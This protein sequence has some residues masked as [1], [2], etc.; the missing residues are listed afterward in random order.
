MSPLLK[1]VIESN[2]NNELCSKIRSYLTNPKR[3]E[4]PQIYLKGLKVEN[5]LLMKRNWLWVANKNQLQL[6]VIKEIHNQPA[7]GH[8]STEKTLEMAWYHYYWPRVKEM[9]QQFIRNCYM[10]KQAK[11]AWDTYHSLLQLLL[12]PKQTWTDITIDFVVEL[13][14]CKA[15][16]QIYDA[17]LMVI[18]QL[19]KKIHYIPCFE[20]D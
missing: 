17:I 8:S 1:R 9:I 5:R 14:K 19:F 6:K 10:C 4:K 16:G 12:V 2:Q 20:E 18:D 13:L 3:L 11:A 7:V 15:Y